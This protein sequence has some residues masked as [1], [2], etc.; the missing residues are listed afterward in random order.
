MSLVV[1]GV[2]QPHPVLT[3]G[4]STD[5]SVSSC[6]PSSSILSKVSSMAKKLLDLVLRKNASGGSTS[7]VATEA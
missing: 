4:L 3:L 7:V 5:G 2:G 1:S 6:L